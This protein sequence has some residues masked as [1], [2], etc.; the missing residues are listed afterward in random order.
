MDPIANRDASLCWFCLSN[1]ALEKHLIVNIEEESYLTLAK[2]GLSEWGGHLLI[3]PIAHQS[4][5]IHLRK[6][7]DAES[8]NPCLEEMNRM[9]TEI[10][11]AFAKKDSIMV[12]FE[13]F[14]GSD[15]GERDRL[16]HM[17]VQVVSL[18]AELVTEVEREFLDAAEK[19]G[20]E[21]VDENVMDQASMDDPFIRLDLPI[22]EDYSLPLKTTHKT[23]WLKATE[24]AIEENNR[25][26]TESQYSGRRPPRL[27]DIQFGR[28]VLATLMGKPD[29]VNWK[30][31]ILPEDKEVE[32]TLSMRN[33]L[34]GDST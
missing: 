2:G 21:V 8:V 1:P 4:S 23:I 26:V 25:L 5:S 15:G 30:N 6:S 3:V 7:A 17:H 29:S 22:S 12:C 33:L 14:S 20:L 27:L 28:R 18:P 31:C 9:K 10:R 11:D 34:T 24:A 13:I 32:L 19:A 16:Q